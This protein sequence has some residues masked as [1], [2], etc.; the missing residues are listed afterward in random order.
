MEKWHE[1]FGR[2]HEPSEEQI[3]EY[4]NTSLFDDLDGHLRQMYKIKPKIAYS[5]CG[6]DGGTWKGWNIK[7]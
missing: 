7:Y 5:G 4:V 3:N 1:L 2:E 6:M